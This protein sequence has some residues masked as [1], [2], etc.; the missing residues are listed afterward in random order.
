MAMEIAPYKNMTFLQPPSKGDNTVALIIA[1]IANPAAIPVATTLTASPSCR[2]GNHKLQ[3]LFTVAG[4]IA[5]R[6]PNKKLVATRVVKE[7]DL[8][9]KAIAIPAKKQAI[10]STRFA[11]KRSA[12]I[13]PSITTNKPA[14][15]TMPQTIPNCTKLKSRS[16]DISLNSTGIA[17]VGMART[18]VNEVA[19]KVS[20]YHLY[21]D[22][23]LS[24]LTEVMARISSYN[25]N[26][27]LDNMACPYKGYHFLS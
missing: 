16:S 15:G 26:Q 11:P 20:M 27:Y 6:R 14:S 25:N 18:N 24:P 17:I 7:L 4:I 5:V 19:A 10:V 21:F 9:I 2:S 22:L 13:P 8:P 3:V 1:P 12:N 23:L